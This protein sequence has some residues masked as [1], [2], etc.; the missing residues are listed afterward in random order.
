MRAIQF[1]RYGP[2]NV[3]DLVDL[4]KPTPGPHECLVRVGATS[5]NPIDWKIRSGML[6]RIMRIKLPFVPGYDVCGVIEDVAQDV[7][8]FRQ[9]DS[10][11]V[12]VQTRRAG[13]YAEN[14]VVP[15]E[16]CVPKPQ[17]LSVI[18]AA[19]MPLAGLTALQAL[20]DHG[21]IRTGHHVLVIGASGGVGHYAVQIVKAMGAHVTGVCGPTNVEMVK[22][23]GADEV[24]DYRK[25]DIGQLDEKYDLILDAVAKHSFTAVRHLLAPRGIYVT[26]LPSFQ[27]LWRM[28][29]MRS[30]SRARCVLAKPRAADLEFLSGLANDGRLRSVVDRVYALTEARAAHEVSE[31]GH[32]AGKLVIAVKD[33]AS[34]LRPA[35]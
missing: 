18:E 22:G 24:I 13:C 14:V 35:D 5:V 1:S 16:L 23:L 3:L 6:K 26:T 11:F 32:V 29:V 28:I 21:K 31:A 10:I 9:G 17:F 30:H 7:T 15:E 25:R 34:M 12:M 20:R 33:D 2:T 8:R 27:V 19:A 4:E